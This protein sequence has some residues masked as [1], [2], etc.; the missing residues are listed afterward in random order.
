[1]L[2]Y[3]DYRIVPVLLYAHNPLNISSTIEPPRLLSMCLCLVYP[4]HV[5]SLQLT[6]LKHP[7]HSA[8]SLPSNCIQ[9]SER[10]HR[11]RL[12]RMERLR[13]RLRHR[14]D[15][16]CTC[17]IAATAERRP[18]LSVDCAETRLPGLQVSSSCRP[19]SAAW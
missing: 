6:I 18:S 16:T 14:Y 11:Q 15:V 1:M 3:R 5:P 13:Y 8:P 9:N 12:G 19:S 10:L 4:E 17:R 7:P 2:H